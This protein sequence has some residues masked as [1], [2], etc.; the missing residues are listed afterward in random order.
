MAVNAK[1]LNDTVICALVSASILLCTT[2]VK[3][4]LKS[5]FNFGTVEM[6]DFN[7][8]YLGGRERQAQ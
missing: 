3:T 2:I 7:G 4:N 6:E 8:R 5:H 1:Y